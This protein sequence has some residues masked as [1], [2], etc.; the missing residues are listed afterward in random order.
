MRAVGNEGLARATIP[1]YN[2]LMIDYGHVLNQAIGIAERASQVALSYFRQALLIEMKANLTPVTIADKKT[3]EAIRADLSRIF[4]KHGILGEEFGEHRLGGDYVWTIDPIDGTRSFVRGIPLWGTLLG[5]LE[6]G[7]PVVGVMVIP[8][9]GE[10]YSAAKGLG[11][12]C[13][14][15][16]LHV[17]PVRSL[18][19]GIVACG[20]LS[21]F[22]SAGKR[23]F[24]DALTKQAELVRGYTDCFGHALVARGAIDAMIDP[25]VSI[26]DVAPL[27]CII[28]EAGGEYFTF[29]GNPSIEGP[30]FLTCPPQLKAE[31]LAL[32]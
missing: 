16:Q 23:P 28:R 12:Y 32:V 13:N 4:P 5:L 2:R 25:V 7:Q 3:E 10:T 26:W 18:G 20:D 15:A 6:K 24:L 31:L 1:P 22:E 19:S 11:T 27:A 9:L 17:S 21:S 29:D 8:A 14:G 30:S